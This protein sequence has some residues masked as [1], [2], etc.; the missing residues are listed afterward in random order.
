MNTLKKA[1]FILMGLLLG[2]TKLQAQALDPVLLD[3]LPRFFICIVAG[4]LLAIGFQVVLTTLSVATGITAM[5]DLKKKGHQALHGNNQGQQNNKKNSTPASVKISSGLG[6]WT[7]ITCSLSLFAAS[8]L[9][10]QLSLV[11]TYMTALTLGLVI[12]AA[13]FTTIVYLESKAVS[14]LV[15]GM[16]SVMSKGIRTAFD[17]VKGVTGGV[18][19]E[20]ETSRGKEIARAGAQE[21]AV[22]MRH[23]LETLFNR[24]DIDYKIDDYI[25]RLEPKYDM[26]QIKKEVKDLLTDLEVKE[27]SKAGE[28]GVTKEYF[29][30]TASKMPNVTQEDMQ[31]LSAAFDQAKGIAQGSGSRQQKAEQAVEQFTSASKEDIE[32]FKEKMSKYLKSTK[33]EEFQPDKIQHDFEEI[34]NNPKSASRILNNKAGAID[35]DTIVNV[36]ESRGDVSHDDAE[37]YAHYAEKALDYLKENLNLKSQSQQK[38]GELTERLQQFFTDLQDKKDYNVNQIKRDFN[39]MFRG[40]GDDSDSLL[41]KLKHYDKERIGQMVAANSNIPEHKVEQVITSLEE[42]R[43]QMVS[44]AEEAK[45]KVNEA[46]QKAEEE[47]LTQAENTRKAAAAAAWWLFAAAISSAAASAVGGVLAL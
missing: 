35:H 40:T 17:T 28:D 36:I 5:G 30:E 23:Q 27:T 16:I 43:D 20:S 37:K 39:N 6:V 4:V 29:L 15:G 7:V 24:H 14:S 41:T 26:R 18:F 8:W 46:L 12:W 34:L 44:M 19:G 21:S 45:H 47:T 2:V 10:V 42:S 31:Q 13:F 3:N 33:K 32:D 11:G 1:T 22:A 38:S 25:Q 9:A